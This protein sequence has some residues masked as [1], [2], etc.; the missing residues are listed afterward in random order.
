MTWTVDKYVEVD[1][2]ATIVR[3]MIQG[4]G[5]LRIET[6]AGG[7]KYG[8]DEDDDL[9]SNNDGAAEQTLE[10]GGDKLTNL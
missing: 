9:G 6:G 8:E 2:E 5:M 1:E 3:S 7:F 4:T 10:E